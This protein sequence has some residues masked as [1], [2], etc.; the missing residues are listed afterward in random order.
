MKPKNPLPKMLAGSVHVQYVRCGK[1]TCKSA[2]SDLLHGPY[3]YHFTRLKSVLVK[4]Y[5]KL[6][7]VEQIRA[8]CNAGRQEEGRHR[9]VHKVNARQLSKATEHLR[10]NEKYLLQFLGLSHEQAKKSS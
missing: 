8:A 1:S 3:F 4:R 5:V 10:E 2:G 6:K 9:Q 7:E